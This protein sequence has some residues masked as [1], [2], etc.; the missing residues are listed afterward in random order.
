MIPRMGD[1]LK[2]HESRLRRMAARRGLV[3][4]KDRRRD[5]GAADYGM[6]RIS[7]AGLPDKMVCSSRDL[8]VIERFLSG[9]DARSA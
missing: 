2:V 3:L 1:E 7:A 6:Y 9:Y 5:P 8:D 4:R